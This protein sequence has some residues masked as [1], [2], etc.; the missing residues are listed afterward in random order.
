M[1]ILLSKAVGFSSAEVVEVISDDR[2]RIK[3]VFG[4]DSGPASELIRAK[5][6][7]LRAVGNQGLQFK[8]TPY[9]DHTETYRHV[10][11]DLNN[12]GSIVI[13]PEGEL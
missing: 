7:E 10:Y 9:V 6:Q 13:F 5:L 2:L 8:K 1:Q 11:H 4:N 12:G 3:K